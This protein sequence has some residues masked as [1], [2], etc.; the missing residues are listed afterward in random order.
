[1]G[2]A[3]SRNKLDLVVSAITAFTWTDGHGLID[4]AGNA[5]QEYIFYKESPSFYLLHTFHQV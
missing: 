3:C 2:V 4:S 1:V 5:D